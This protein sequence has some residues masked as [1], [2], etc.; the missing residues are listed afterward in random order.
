MIRFVRNFFIIKR[1][2]RYGAVENL[3]VRYSSFCRNKPGYFRAKQSQ[4]SLFAYL[5]C[6]TAED[7]A[8]RLFN[9]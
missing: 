6:Q 5:L 9:I 2:I 8:I 3:G 1:R 4:I 7:S